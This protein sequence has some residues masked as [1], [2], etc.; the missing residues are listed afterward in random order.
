[1]KTENPTLSSFIMYYNQNFHVDFFKYNGRFQIFINTFFFVREIM[2]FLPKFQNQIIIK[3][4]QTDEAVLQH[5]VKR[6]QMLDEIEDV[7]D[8]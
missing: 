2:Q 3:N 8:R 4:R 5:S 1:M 6:Q 7:Q